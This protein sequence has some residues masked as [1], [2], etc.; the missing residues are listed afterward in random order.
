MQDDRAL[1]PVTCVAVVRTPPSCVISSRSS[2][3]FR[4]P[5]G[6]GARPHTCAGSRKRGVPRRCMTR[7]RRRN[8]RLPS[9]PRT[10]ASSRIRSRK[11]RSASPPPS[12]CVVAALRRAETCRHR[13]RC[14][15]GCSAGSAA[16]AGPRLRLARAARARFRSVPG[17]P[18]SVPANPAR[19]SRC[20]P[21]LHHRRGSAHPRQRRVWSAQRRTRGVGFRDGGDLHGDWITCRRGA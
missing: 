10:S 4:R 6:S 13:A 15:K 18:R 12:F 14:E 11:T 17:F 9:H 1:D 3:K 8:S 7:S 21:P 5:C 2:A 20:P 16:P 19:Q